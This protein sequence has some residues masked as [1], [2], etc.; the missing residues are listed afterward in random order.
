M[1][2]Q[3]TLTSE[4]R[5]A[6]RKLAEAARRVQELAVKKKSAKRPAEKREARPC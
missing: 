5:K 2:T 6:Y 4:E 1:H 3:P